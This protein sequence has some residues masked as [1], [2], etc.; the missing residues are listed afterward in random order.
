MKL[1]DKR[2]FANTASKSGFTLLEMLIVIVVIIILMGVVFKLS[3][4]AM[5]NAERSKEVARVLKLKALVEEFHAEYGIYPPVPEYDGVQPV[6]FKGALPESGADLNYYISHYGDG[7]CFKFGLMSFFVDRT[8]YCSYTFSPSV[9]GAANPKARE[10]WEMFN[11]KIN[12]MELPDP[13]PK[14]KA[15]IKRVKPILDTI[16]ISTPEGG[17]PY[18]ADGHTTGFDTEV[19]D[20]WSHEYVYISEPPYTSY[21]LFSP[22]PDGAYDKKAPEDRSKPA[23][24]DN[25]YAELGDK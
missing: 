12:G 25:V 8:K 2:R 9:G 22:G 24:K 4:G 18:D 15:F 14:D 7:L 19:F 21:I 20:L 5:V 6:N 1:T 3:K 13:S 17:F 23:N 16:G 10:A 11:D